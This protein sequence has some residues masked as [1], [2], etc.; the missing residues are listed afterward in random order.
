MWYLFIAPRQ[1]SSR[2]RE[3]SY[4]DATKLRLRQSR[5]SGT[6]GQQVHGEVEDLHDLFVLA[7][8][9]LQIAVAGLGGGCC[10]VT[11]LQ[12]SMECE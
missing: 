12:E 8:Y 9:V 1:V 3:L 5:G 11:M 10:Y 2:I 4:C 7:G 6:K